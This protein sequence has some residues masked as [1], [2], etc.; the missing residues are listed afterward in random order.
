MRFDFRQ[1]RQAAIADTARLDDI[2][3]AGARRAR[4]ETSRTME[5]VHEA[6]GF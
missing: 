5:L 2:L 6:L 1:R 3:A 4:E